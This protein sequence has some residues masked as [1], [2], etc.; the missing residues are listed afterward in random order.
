MKIGLGL[1]NAVP[2]VPNGRLLVDLA[3]R[4][5]TL[6]FSSLGTLGRIA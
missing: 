2:D 6:G 5:E 1:P 4:A 3:V